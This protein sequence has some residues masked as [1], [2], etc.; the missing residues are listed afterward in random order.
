MKNILKFI[1]FFIAIAWI[2]INI[3]SSLN[4]S[5]F[6][7]RIYKITSGSMK[8]NLMI[9]DIIIIKEDKEYKLGD[10]VTFIDGKHYTTHRIV[11]KK[12]EIVTTKGDNNNTNDPSI[13]KN[14]IV[15]KE[16]LKLNFGFLNFL[17]LKPFIWVLLFVIGIMMIFVFTPR[18]F[19]V[20]YIEYD[21]LN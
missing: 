13:N 5:L 20:K 6:G 4:H 18:K 15:G 19:N 10:I 9:N 8:P 7:F 11:E 3:F 17:L 16:I 14:Q 21:S 1:F 12:G 2:S